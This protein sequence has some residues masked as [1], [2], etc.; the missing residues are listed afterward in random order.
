MNNSTNSDKI[1]DKLIDTLDKTNKIKPFGVML[2]CQ[3][4]K[5]KIYSQRTIKNNLLCPNCHNPLT[6]VISFAILGTN[7][8]GIIITDP[9]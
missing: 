8:G 5:L 4:C 9:C 3:S 6:K 2:T 7:D 1:S